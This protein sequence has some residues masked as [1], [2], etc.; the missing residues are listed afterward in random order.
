MCQLIGDS[1]HDDTD[2]LQSMIDNGNGELLLPMPAVCYRISRPLVLPSCFRLALPRYAEVKLDDGS[3]CVMLTNRREETPS[4]QIEVSGGI[5]N[6]HNKG[7]TENPLLTKQEHQTDYM[8]YGFF[9]YRVS[10]LKLSD[11]TL[12][13]PV[14]FAVTLDTVSYFTVEDITFDYNHGNPAPVNM[15]GIHLN[16]NC[17]Y[18]TLRNLKGTCYDDLVALNADEGSDGP[19]THIEIDGIFSEGCHSAVRL[20]TVKNRVENIHI[21]NVHGTYYQ[22][23]IGLT[24]YYE[25][26]TTGWFDAIVLEQI[27]ASKAVRHSLYQKDGSYVYP[28]IYVEGGSR[29][30][31]LIIRGVFRQEFNIP[32]ETVHI[33]SNTVV[34]LLSID[35]LSVEN[36]TGAHMP[37]I[38]NHGEVN[39][40]FIGQIDGFGEEILQ[41]EG[42]IRQLD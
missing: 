33:G 19:I 2:A 35:T 39:R 26:E 12:K 15:D 3:D 37:V 42:V 16:G 30:K 5:W 20:L 9:F 18:G 25:G 40:A 32:V 1:I 24:K 8:G 11:M 31:S 7:Q 28:L 21:R 29:V 23:C 13:D 10:G 14:T 17:H 6:F 36:H 34:R 27:F 4:R 41:N 22:Y 38:V